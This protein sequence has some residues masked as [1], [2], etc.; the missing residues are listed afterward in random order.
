MSGDHVLS[1][2]SVGIT[3]CIPAREDV[4]SAYPLIMRLFPK[5]DW[6]DWFRHA[7]NVP[8]T[9]I[10]FHDFLYNKIIDYPFEFY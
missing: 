9:I 1:V 2:I 3:V 5:M 6:R 4:V 7:V 8:F 10:A